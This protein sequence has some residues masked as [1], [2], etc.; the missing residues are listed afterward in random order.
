M[1]IKDIAREA[2]VSVSAVSLVLNDKPC[3]ISAEKKALIK[4]IAEKNQYRPNP[5]ARSLVMQHTSTLGLIIPDIGNLFFSE[6]AKCL[7]KDCRERGYLLFIAN[8]DDS[9][10]NDL[11]LIRMFARQRV[12]GLFLCVSNEAF[13]N[14]DAVIE[15][16]QELPCPYVM[17]DRA[18]RDFH[19]DKVFY[20]NETGAYQA[21]SLLLRMGH[22]EIGCITPPYVYG[23]MKARF[24]GYQKAMAE[25]G[26]AIAP[27]WLAEGDYRFE[28]GYAA[29]K[30]LAGIT[31]AAFAANDMMSLGF[32][33]YLF[34][35]G[36]RVPED[37]SLV[38]YDHVASTYLFHLELASVEQN[39]PQ[40]GRAAVNV[41]FSR[42]GKSKSL[43]TES[44]ILEPRF[45]QGN[46][47]KAI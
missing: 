35:A 33:K 8:S 6:L 36:I 43:S 25:Y 38:S 26:V 10:K 46:S 7:E 11:D 41:L 20:D 9:L 28:S 18:F 23:N 15:A 4:S 13:R 5:I 27:E 17:V 22:R 34:E 31:T 3:R 1:T 2:G 29:G 39:I 40:M 47:I 30:K 16:L 24:K 32:L 12:D 37:Y 44:V 42:M 45:I 19:C 14:R 21:V